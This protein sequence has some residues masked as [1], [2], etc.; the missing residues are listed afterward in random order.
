MS[1]VYV[2]IRTN[3]LEESEAED[4]LRQ[5]KTA[6]EKRDYELSKTINELSPVADYPEDTEIWIEKLER[7][8]KSILIEAYSG[9]IEPPLWFAAALAEIGSVKTQ[10]REQWDEGGKTYYFMG[11]KKVT[12]KVYH[13]DNK[14]LSQKDIEIN[15]TLFLPEGRIA[16]TAT[17]LDFYWDENDYG[18]FCVM[19]MVTDQGEHFVY[20]GSSVLLTDLTLAEYENTCQ[21]FAVFERGTLAGE[22]VSFAKRPTKIKLRKVSK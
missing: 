1:E 4:R 13:G 14:P 10:I 16:I 20:K 11:K 18:E 6:A 9:R 5:L 22:Y 15:K 2:S 3:F 19:K 17:L 21:F 12:K 7:K 8:H